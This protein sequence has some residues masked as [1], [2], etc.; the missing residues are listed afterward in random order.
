MRLDFF[1]ISAF[2]AALLFPLAANATINKC[3]GA[4]GKILFSDQP[5]MP[6]QAAATLKDAGDTK[7]AAT[8]GKPT[9]PVDPNA[10]M[11]SMRNAIEAALSPE[12][13]QMQK[14]LSGQAP[15]PGTVR[16]TE[17][18]LQ[19]MTGLF[20]SQCSPL[21]KAAQESELAKSKAERELLQ[22]QVECTEKRRV[23]D[24]RKGKLSG[25]D[26]IGRQAMARLTID[27]ERNCR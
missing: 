9:M 16:L 6:G 2:L 12:C 14:Q 15:G 25:L 27:L 17:V 1:A 19:R 22:K 18:E 10:A 7:P 8:Y 23:Y 5:C 4:D 11:T 24:E 26:D 21:I 13:R 3:T 20:E